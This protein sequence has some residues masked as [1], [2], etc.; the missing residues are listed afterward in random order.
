MKPLSIITAMFICVIVASIT[1]PAYA[2]EAEAERQG[3]PFPPERIEELEEAREWQ[4]PEQIMEFLDIQEGN[5]VA[6]IG[7]GTGYFALYLSDAVGKS[8][9]VYA[10]DIQQEMVD[11][12]QEK[13][14]EEG[15]KNTKVILGEPD[16]P[17]LPENSLDL[18]LMGNVYH[19]VENPVALLKSIARSLKSDGSLVI[20]DWRSDVESEFGPSMMERV[21]E[22]AVEADAE[23]AGYYMVRHHPFL[24]YHYFLI[25]KKRPE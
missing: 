11:Y 2:R 8:G 7:T 23:E 21:S 19:E 15:I 24:R 9:L 14:E 3:K 5:V 20:I 22:D 18:A 17:K 10:E 25:F 1:F 12:T 6:D 4:K 13:I 16:D